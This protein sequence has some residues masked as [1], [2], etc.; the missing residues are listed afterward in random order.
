MHANRLLGL[1]ILALMAIMSC[2]FWLTAFIT[3]QESI[4]NANSAYE[5]MTIVIERLRQT[6]GTGRVIIAG[7]SAARYGIRTKAVHKV[8]ERPVVSVAVSRAGALFSPYAASILK[9]V[10]PGDTIV[11]FGTEWVY[12]DLPSKARLNASLKSFDAIVRSNQN[13]VSNPDF[14]PL[15]QYLSWVPTTSIWTYL[16]GQISIRALMRRLGILPTA[17]YKQVDK[18]EAS[19]PLDPS[20][21]AKLQIIAQAP[22]GYSP[23]LDEQLK[24]IKQF[25]KDI[26][27]RGGRLI[28]GFPWVFTSEYSLS[29][30]NT[31]GDRLETELTQI[32]TV[33][34]LEFA[35]SLKADQ[36]YFCD[37]PAHTSPLGSDLWTADVA[38]ALS[39]YFKPNAR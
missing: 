34:P 23:A 16:R 1:K 11:Y 5:E 32:T 20:C 17:P 25:D 2:Y 29:R 30:W 15:Y 8:L 22:L 37:M 10:R 31:Y 36:R 33:L 27:A 28:V 3:R 4:D 21:T 18:A 19:L 35:A 38:T 9:E 13:G 24:Q 6:K 26:K 7:G 12:P 14:P 39:A